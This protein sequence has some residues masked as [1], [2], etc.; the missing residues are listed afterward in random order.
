M[1][2][3][4][5]IDYVG[6]CT[7]YTVTD[8]SCES[9]CSTL[10]H[11]DVVY[12]NET[13]VWA[14]CGAANNGVHCNAPTT[15]TFVAEAPADMSTTYTVLQTA[16]TTVASSDTTT[17]SSPASQT[18]SPSSSSTASSQ[19]SDTTSTTSGTSSS[20]SDP[21]SHSTGGGL[22]T[23]AKAAIAVVGALVGAVAGGLFVMWY[24]R[25][26]NERRQQQQNDLLAPEPYQYLGQIEPHDDK[27]MYRGQ[28]QQL[29][30]LVPLE[31]LE[32][33]ERPI[34][35]HEN[36]RAELPGNEYYAHR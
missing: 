4:F 18:T 27:L 8:S 32:T 16:S 17:T 15:I 2:V 23:G 28:Q 13:D 25:C 12:N 36:N 34:E 6:G 35:L 1:D 7:D 10:V 31:E 3:L 11:G 22:S 30:P 21:S 33:T 29:S 26:Q 20:N 19:A 24:L 14:C 9:F 5:V